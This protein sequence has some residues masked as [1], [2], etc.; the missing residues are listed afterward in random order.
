MWDV[1]YIMLLGHHCIIL[2]GQHDAA[3]QHCIF[4]HITWRALGQSRSHNSDR[5][6]T[7]CSYSFTTVKFQ[8]I[9]YTHVNADVVRRMPRITQLDIDISLYGTPLAPY[10]SNMASSNYWSS[11]LEIYVVCGDVII[12]TI[13]MVT[14]LRRH[15]VDIENRGL[16]RTD[17]MYSTQRALTDAGVK[18]FFVRITQNV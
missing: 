13:S 16:C 18:H 5:D 1:A 2:P 4:M 9:F 14:T 8:S 11:V 15:V 12:Y 3:R 7:L 10:G 6:I 17:E